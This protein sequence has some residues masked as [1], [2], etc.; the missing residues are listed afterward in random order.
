VPIRREWND[1][2]TK[3]IEDRLREILIA[4]YRS[5]EAERQRSERFRLAAARRAEE[6][7]RRWERE[8]RE[9]HEREAVE[10]LL[11]EANAWED[12][13]R[14]RNYVRA[15]KASGVRNSEW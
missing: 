12:A 10:S 4:L 6:E 1:T 15:M 3:R 11:A 2:E 8:G 7:R 9:R 5:I 14:T 13:Q